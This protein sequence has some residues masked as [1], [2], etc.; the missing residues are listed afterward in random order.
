MQSYSVRNREYRQRLGR[1]N[2]PARDLG[3]PVL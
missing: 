1:G 3:V 2:R